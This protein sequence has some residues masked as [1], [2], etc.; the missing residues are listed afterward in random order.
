M[1]AKKRSM[2][3]WLKW[4][5]LAPVLAFSIAPAV[6]QAGSLYAGIGFGNAKLDGQGACGTLKPLLNK[7]YTCSQDDKDT[8]WKILGGYQLMRYLAFELAYENLGTATASATGT[9]TGTSTAATGSSRYEATGFN[10]SALGLLPITNELGAFF[11]FG[12]F[13][14]NMDASASTPSRSISPKDTKPGFTPNN[15]G[16]GLKYSVNK[17]IDVR[18]E[19]ERFKDIGD[20]DITGQADID[21]TS[22]GLIYK[23]Q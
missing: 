15:V 23:F 1:Y 11:R 22:L 2:T 7:G 12:T 21:R 4:G 14:W 19:W 10:F 5:M 18:F 16:L 3:V 9:A 13:R 20:T 17:T 6:V 8:S